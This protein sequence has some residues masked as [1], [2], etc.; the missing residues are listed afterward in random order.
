MLRSVRFYS[1]A[2]PWPA[3]EE[4]LSE[5]LFNAAFKPCGPLTA[6]SAGWEPPAGEQ[7]GL[8]T[9][10]VAGAD[11]L[12]LR[13][14]A[15][16]LPAAAVNE[17]LEARIAEFRARTQEEPTRRV[18]RQLKEQTRDDLLPKALLK[19]DRM[20]G[21]YLVTDD[22]L[23]IGTASES[24]A[25]RFLESLRAGLGA[26]DAQPLRFPRPFTDLMVQV[27]AGEAPREFVLGRE[28]RM[29]DPSEA[30]GVVRWQDVDL[31]HS[32]VRK[33]LK[34]GMHLTHL[35]FE[36]GNVMSAVLD[37]NGALTKVKLLGTE[38]PPAEGEED[39]LA[40]LDAELALLGG[41]LRQLLQSLG[42]ALGE[43]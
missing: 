29:R 32:T 1:I 13:T 6:Q 7:H 43:S 40:R 31:A 22:V 14:Q 37:A 11:L 5:K 8:L 2:T 41:T 10:R 9:R 15:R 3:S 16:L 39:E 25:E 4:E 33:C 19:S 34:D 18:R 28:C 42:K 27:F 12:R 23:A 35:H 26:L 30:K 36:F 38:E 17:A 24:R 20:S 21:L